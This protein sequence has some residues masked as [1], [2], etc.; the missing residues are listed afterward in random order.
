MVFV[1]L[2]GLIF[3]S[4]PDNRMV[5]QIADW[6]DLE[7]HERVA[8]EFPAICPSAAIGCAVVNFAAHRCDVY[9]SSN[10]SAWLRDHEL[11][12]CRGYDHPPFALHSAH[13]A[14]VAAGRPLSPHRQE[15]MTTAQA[16]LPTSGMIGAPDESSVPSLEKLPQ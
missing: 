5:S 11:Q 7:I 14:W 2:V 6:P 15:E 13:A 12:H 4:A 8:T 16:P 10:S 1:F 3:A 9:L